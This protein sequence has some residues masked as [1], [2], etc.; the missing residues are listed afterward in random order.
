MI[1]T[2][3]KQLF[4][5]SLVFALALFPLIFFLA[6]TIY[7]QRRISLV[8]ILCLFFFIVYLIF[9]FNRLMNKKAVVSMR[10]QDERERI[11]LTESEMNHEKKAIQAFKDKIVQVSYLK[12]LTEK[13]SQCLSLDETIKTLSAEIPQIFS[14]KNVCLILFLY[15]AKSGELILTLSQKDKNPLSVKSKKGDLFDQWTIKN[16]QPL[17]VEDIHN[18]YRF[19]LD[20]H[21]LDET[22]TFQSLIASPL[23]VG[24]KVWGII[25][26]DSPSKNYF[27]VDDLRFLTTISDLAAVAIE[28]AKL[29][30]R[31]EQMAIKDGLT[32][33]Y[34]RRF[35]LE[36]MPEE[37]SRHSRRGDEMSFLMIDLDKFKDYN[38]TFG[39]IAGDIVLRTVGNLLAEFFAEPGYVVARYGGEE[40]A[41]LLPHCSKHKALQ[42]AEKF[43]KKIE[44]QELLLR[45]EK[46]HMTVSIGVAAFPQDGQMK[47]D[48]IYKADKALYKAKQE[49]R[50]RVCSA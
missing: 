11:N 15:H 30:E 14:H 28:N 47:E 42:L 21:P 29:Y 22:R 36:R 25:R 27:T 12:D 1:K 31:L 23:L 39:H 34:L 18:D 19:D 38:D 3:K 44:S 7:T 24:H 4:K 41:V 10:I 5:Q 17:I 48:I 35:L 26:L 49:G 32:G 37:L 46:T 13:L 2:L 9:V 50:N 33:L 6:Y 43:R 40:F 20:R 16:L 8:F 45:R